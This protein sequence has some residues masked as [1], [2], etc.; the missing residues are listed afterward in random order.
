MVQQDT[1]SCVTAYRKIFPQDINP[2]CDLDLEESNPNLPQSTPA[3]DDAPLY[4]IGLQKV[5]EFRRS[6]RKLF[7][8][9]FSPHCD[10]N[11]DVMAIHQLP[12]FITK[13]EVV[14]KISLRQIFHDNLN[15]H[16]D[17][18]LEDSN[19]KLSHTFWLMMMHHFTKFGCNRYLCLGVYIWYCI[20]FY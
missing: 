18:D 15:P 11:L 9:D 2:H 3:R 10:H 12:S 5:Q 8:E 4:Q 6:G 19:P 1:H 14:P 13:G 16:S 17:L 20:L 7:F